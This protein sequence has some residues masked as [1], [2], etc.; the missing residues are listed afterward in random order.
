MSRKNLRSSVPRQRA[1][2]RQEA[3]RRAVASLKRR[4]RRRLRRFRVPFEDLRW[5]CSPERLP[6]KTTASIEP[7]RKI[8]GQDKAL[9]SLTVGIRMTSPGYN[10]F[11][12]GLPG[13]GRSPALRSV[14]SGFRRRDG[15]PLDFCYVPNFEAQEQPILLTFKA[16]QGASFRRDVLSLLREVHEA[17]ERAGS[18]AREKQLRS[19]VE[20]RLPRLI[21]RYPQ[22]RAEEYLGQ[23]GR[24]VVASDGAVS[25]DEVGVNLLG[26]VVPGGSPVVV[27]TSISHGTLFGFIERSHTVRGKRAPLPP[28][29]GIRAGAIVQAAG[30]VL[31]LQ[32][33]E[34][35][36][37]KN[38][39]GRLRSCL[40]HGKLEILDQDPGSGSFRSAIHPEPVPIQL[41]VIL[42]GD[43]ESY[44]KFVD[45][46]ADL[47]Q[48]FKVRVEFDSEVNR[49]PRL[50]EQDYPAFIARIVRDEKLR[51]FSAAA[52]ARIIEFAVRRAGRKNKISTQFSAVADLA[53]E[54]S[55]W[56][57]RG[58][59]RLVGADDVQKAISEN[60]ARLNLVETK[61]GEM[62]IDG[63][64][65]IDTA[66][67]RVGQVNGLAVY[68]QGDYVFGKPSRITAETSVGQG[69]IINIERESGFSGRSHD[70]GIQILGGYLR[71]R[72]AQ[73]RPLS[74]TASVCFE[75]SYS[76]VD[77]DSASSSEI[78]AILSSLS[79][80]P[81]RQDLAVTGSMNQKGDIQPIGGVNEKIEG[82]YDCVQAGRPTGREG[83]IVPR[84]N[85]SDLMLREDI[86]RDVRRGRFHIYAIR[87][88]EEGIEILTGLP[89]GRLSRGGGYS[90]GSVFWRADQRLE[91]I[92]AGL[93]QSASGQE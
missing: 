2:R 29:A 67:H 12:C 33:A 70:K 72:F 50:I 32:A 6:F 20:E 47:P 9:R 15:Q 84:R 42:V 3:V 25:A 28:H 91:E 39:W 71:S 85:L 45:L 83:V 63:T 80:L 69:G 46:D 17:R 57:G 34:L 36:E 18:W 24:V 82:F 23:L 11:V 75:Q 79:G 48:F 31:V 43:Y 27:P 89:A 40:E 87:S 51:H 77:G 86:V 81:I 41:K 88:V 61:M 64:I 22:D 5:T 54:A 55:F 1:L 19:L 78:Y 58:R 60:T 14:L 38:G 90:P 44:D 7:S 30:G 76:G 62:I 26:P 59:R 4:F 65:L 66:G 8:V 93:R 35:L 92:A 68:D 56:A 13:T 16:G 52:V 53:R 37:L 21:A 74:L 10:I 49:T 73:R